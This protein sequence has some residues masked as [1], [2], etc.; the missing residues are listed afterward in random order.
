M[1]LAPSGEP[2]HMFLSIKTSTHLI[3]LSFPFL[4]YK[5]ITFML[6]GTVNGFDSVKHSFYEQITFIIC[7]ITVNLCA[8]VE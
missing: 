2:L 3:F 5:R 7:L 1:F 6:L 8:N 4:Y